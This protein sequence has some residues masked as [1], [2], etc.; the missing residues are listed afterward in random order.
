M[1]CIGCF[2]TFAVVR[3]CGRRAGWSGRSGEGL[4]SGGRCAG[5]TRRLIA[6]R[7]GALAGGG[8]Q[9]D[10]VSVVQEHG[11]GAAGVPADAQLAVP[12]VTTGDGS[13]VTGPEPGVR[14]C[15]VFQR[16]AVAALVAG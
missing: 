10:A 15:G 13:L 14:V 7:A 11:Q 3:R 12:G 8:D 6:V 1:T 4:E 16:D 9:A 2:L 5:R